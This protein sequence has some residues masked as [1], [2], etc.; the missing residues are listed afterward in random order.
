M[1]FQ[2]RLARRMIAVLGNTVTGETFSK[3]PREGTPQYTTRAPQTCPS[4]T[5]ILRHSTTGRNHT[6]QPRSRPQKL[7]TQTIPVVFR[8]L[9]MRAQVRFP[10]L[11]WGFFLEGDSHGGHGLVLGLRPHLVLHIHISPSTS[12]GHVVAL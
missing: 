1:K 12:S 2:R 6:T 11:T 4:H 8:L 7:F 3:G 9:I 10:V 5:H